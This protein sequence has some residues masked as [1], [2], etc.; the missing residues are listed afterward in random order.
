MQCLNAMLSSISTFLWTIKQRS[1][2]PVVVVQE[3]YTCIDLAAHVQ[4]LLMVSS[5]DIAH[6]AV[7]RLIGDRDTLFLRL[8][9]R[10]CDH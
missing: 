5:V 6:K 4:R 3:D 2:E 7:P 10:D 1:Q 9:R 8:E